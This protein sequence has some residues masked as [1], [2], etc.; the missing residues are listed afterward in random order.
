MA[1]TF[2]GTGTTSGTVSAYRFNN[3]KILDHAVRRAGL[4]PERLSGEQQQIGLD[5]LFSQTSEWINAGFPL[6]TR[7]FILLGPTIGS[8]DVP[9]PVGTVD[10]FHTYWRILQPYR[11]NA[12]G[13]D[14][15]NASVL[16]AGQPN[17]DITIAG[18]NP[19]VIVFFGGVGPTELDSI[20]VI[21]GGNAPVTAALQ[22]QTSSD[23]VTWAITQTLP[24]ATYT[25]GVWTYFDLDPSVSSTYTALV[26]PSGGSWTL[27]QVQFGLANGQDI[28]IGPL[29]IDDYYNLPNKFF[30]SNQANSSYVDRQITQPVIK[31]WPTPNVTGFYNGA[32]SAL[33][34]RY[35]QD[36]GALT[37]A[38]EVPQRWL[39]A[40]IWRLAS[41]I[42]YEIPPTQD[43]VAASQAS[44]YA[45]L[46]RQQLIQ[47]IEQK[48][49]KAEALAWSEE[50]SRSP[51]KWAP[52]ISPYTR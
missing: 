48:A 43:Q 15:Q 33:V 19:G 49:S 18:P 24:S 17:D 47:Q 7:Q 30:Q 41:T 20:G 8:P 51:I 31:L 35:I 23:G 46:A 32:I 25:P 10:A 12:I 52:N 1:G 5:L 13:T 39:E 21:L 40:T 6:W 4:Q 14:S 44:P 16:F 50:R 45:V 38:L 34:R 2:I 27:N 11:G 28:E 36:P 37:N 42:F 29:N 26:L 9:M 3:Q 22:V